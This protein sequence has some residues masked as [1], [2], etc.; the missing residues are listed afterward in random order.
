METLRETE[1]KMEPAVKTTKWWSPDEKAAFKADLERYGK[2]Y[3]RIHQDIPTKTR[4]QIWSYAKHQRRVR[5]SPV[6][7]VLSQL[8]RQKK[9][10]GPSIWS[11]EE[12]Q[13]LLASYKIYGNL[14][15]GYM[16]QIDKAIPTKTKNQIHS[17]LQT[18][19]HG[20]GFFRGPPILKE[21]KAVIMSRRT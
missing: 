8:D 21:I 11:E 13:L 12:L 14:E 4:D 9:K 20:S 6:K 2:D 19:K 18:I 3:T 17:K 5:N 7:A 16:K 10:A 15:H 1:T